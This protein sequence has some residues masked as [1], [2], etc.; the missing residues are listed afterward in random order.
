[1]SNIDD[2]FHLFDEQE[3]ETIT[4]NPVVL[5]KPETFSE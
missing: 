4:S 1:M 3:D 5:E 2:L